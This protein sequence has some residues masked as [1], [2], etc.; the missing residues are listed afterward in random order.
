V[1]A[2]KKKQ[3]TQM[4]QIRTIELQPLYGGAFCG[5]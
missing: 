1:K 3:F 5:R 2:T 4:Q